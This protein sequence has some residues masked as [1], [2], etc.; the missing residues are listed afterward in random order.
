MYKD[1][2]EMADALNPVSCLVQWSLPRQRLA[3]TGRRDGRAGLKRGAGEVSGGGQ[4]GESSF[5]GPVWS[6]GFC[7]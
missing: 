3:P 1:Q 2:E 4:R 5:Q 6:C 7:S